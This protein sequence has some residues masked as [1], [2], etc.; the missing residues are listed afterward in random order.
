MGAC[1][2]AEG[3]DDDGQRKV[4]TLKRGRTVWLEVYAEVGDKQAFQRRATGLPKW[5]KVIAENKLFRT[6]PGFMI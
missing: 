2:S 6:F 1:T 4:D 3:I 5:L